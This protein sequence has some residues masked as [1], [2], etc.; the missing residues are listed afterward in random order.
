[1]E[2]FKLPENF[3]LGTATSSLQIE[4]GDKN[5]TWYRWSELKKIKDGSHCITSCDHW[6]RVEEDIE[7]MKKLNS[8]IYR[9]SIEW[10]RIEPQKDN[11]NIQAMNHYKDEIKKLKN[12]GIEPLITL[13]HFSNPIWFEDSGGW[14]NDDSI[15]LFERYTEYVV[16]N[17]G[18]YVSEWITIN[19][20]N[21]YL[22]QSFI[23]GN[24]PPGEKGNIKKFLK[25]SKNLIMAHILSYRKIHEVRLN[26]GLKDTKVGVA[27]HLRIFDFDK[28]SFLNRL[29]IKNIDKLFHEIFI[30]GMSEGL[31]L[32]PI[33]KGHPF[34]KGK[35]IDFFG[36]NYYSRDI[37]SFSLNVKNLFFKIKPNEKVEKNDL[38]WEIYPEGIYRIAKKYYERFHLPI[39]ITENGIADSKDNQRCM[40]IYSHLYYINKAIKEGIDI[41]KYYHWTLMDNFEWHEGVSAKFGLI[42]VDFKTKKRTIRKS[43]YFFSEIIKNKGITQ[44]MINKYLK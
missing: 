10:S 2:E 22:Y 11:F 25:A 27:N 43:G 13:H 41:K 44:E 34:G 16:A 9:L 37:I 12:S 19:E 31:L 17:L 40:Y 36:I 38:G 21:V 39:Y 26:K 20:P 30:K 8:E 29:V 18:E 35:Y 32:S 1:M 14:N 23:T 6:K 42:E 7:L 3:K 33:G 28:N 4:G 15:K 24:W 5:N